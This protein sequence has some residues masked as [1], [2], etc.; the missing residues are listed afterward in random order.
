MIG[1][2]MVTYEYFKSFSDPV[3]RSILGLLS[4]ETM[5]VTDLVEHFE[6]SRPAIS[7]HLRVLRE[8]GL[9]SEVK[10]GR[11]RLY[12]VKREVL[13]EA[14]EWL[15]ALAA[16]PDEDERAELEAPV[17]QIR[18]KEETREWRQW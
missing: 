6:V 3:R 15:S 11:E 2:E 7:R 4:R 13:E 14:A 10:M 1:N 9:V 5:N 12:S 16:G 8:G 18:P 17:K